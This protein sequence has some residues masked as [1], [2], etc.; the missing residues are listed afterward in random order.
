M[1][2]LSMDNTNECIKMNECPICLTTLDNNDKS[3]ITVKCCNQQ[4]HMHC[5]LNCM[6]LKKVCP[7]CRNKYTEDES[8]NS[9][10]AYLQSVLPDT[11]VN[12]NLSENEDII[13]YRQRQRNILCLSMSFTIF[14]ILF[15]MRP[16]VLRLL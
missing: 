11:I 16:G 13:L 5:Y 6:N 3:I 15:F 7:L 2:Y 12:I 8:E 1:L 4:F 9:Q 10:N 14:G